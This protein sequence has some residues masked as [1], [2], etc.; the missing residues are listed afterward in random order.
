MD[1]VINGSSGLSVFLLHLS[2]SQPIVSSIVN[3]LVIVLN[4]E[5]EGVMRI[6]LG[7]Y[8]SMWHQGLKLGIDFGW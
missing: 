4:M 6:R 2:Y 3:C 8:S 5:K 1:N 7:V